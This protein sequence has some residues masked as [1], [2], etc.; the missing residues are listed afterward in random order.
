MAWIHPLIDQQQPCPYRRIF[1]HLSKK[2]Q[3]V[4][5]REHVNGVGDKQY[6][7][8]IGQWVGKKVA[9]DDVYPGALKF[10]GE[11]LTRDRAGARQFK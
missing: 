8:P 7:V 5:L 2:L 11:T 3:I 4:R 6:I 10:L 9:F 1:S